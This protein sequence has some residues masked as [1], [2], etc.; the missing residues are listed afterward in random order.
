[1]K[2]SQ[3]IDAL[4]HFSVAM[5]QGARQILRRADPRRLLTPSM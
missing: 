5:Q 4:Q 2:G 1:V 3:C